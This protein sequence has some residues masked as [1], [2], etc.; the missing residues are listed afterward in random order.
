VIVLTS[1][2][3]NEEEVL[4]G[5]GS[6]PHCYAF[7]PTSASVS[8]HDD[9][10]SDRVDCWVRRLV[11]ESRIRSGRSDIR[12]LGYLMANGENYNVHIL[13]KVICTS[14][15]NAMNTRN[16]SLPSTEALLA[17]VYVISPTCDIPR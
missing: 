10:D 7:E 14:W 16:I 8:Y 13:V 11:P 17:I 12:N 4:T 3:D 1:E 5:R 6:F 9:A 15:G 2:S